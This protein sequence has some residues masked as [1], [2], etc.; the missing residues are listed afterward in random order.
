MKTPK[1]ES[2]V[3]KVKIRQHGTCSCLHGGCARIQ[4]TRVLLHGP[5]AWKLTHTG[6]LHGACPWSVSEH[7]SVFWEYLEL[8]MSKWNDSKCYGKLRELSTN[9]MKR[10]KA[11]SIILKVEFIHQWDSIACVREKQ[12]S[13]DR[14]LTKHGP[15][16][17]N[18]ICTGLA[19]TV[20]LIR[21][22]EVLLPK[23]IQNDTDRNF[24]STDRVREVKIARVCCT[25]RVDDPCLSKASVKI[26]LKQHGPW[27]KFARGVLR[28]FNA[29]GSLCTGR[30]RTNQS[31][32][33]SCTDRAEME[34][35]LQN[36]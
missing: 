19:R 35:S 8:Q 28:Q 7:L 9:F 36:F 23:I 34:N 13:T 15:C 25:D 33:V 17:Q 11:E 10:P 6:L 1:T 29:H 21:V 14:N 3:F 4:P 18:Q 31:T 32:R 30:V 24:T 16:A 12:I 2:I 26:C 20:L 27:L 22:E 5:C